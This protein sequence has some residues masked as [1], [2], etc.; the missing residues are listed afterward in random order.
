MGNR[1][2]IEEIAQIA[3]VSRGTVD[4]VLN[5]RPHVRPDVRAKILSAIE[6]T[7]YLSPQEVHRRKLAETFKPL[8]LGV[9]LSNERETQF[10]KEVLLGRE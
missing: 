4:R 8:H 1:T 3:G 6:E 10:R 5:G 2:T 7:G 9:L